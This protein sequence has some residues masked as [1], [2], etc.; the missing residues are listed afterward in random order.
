ME[1]RRTIWGGV[2][3]D[4]TLA[5]LQLALDTE[6]PEDWYPVGREIT[7]TWN[8]KSNPLIVAQYLDSTNNSSYGGAEGVI[9]VRKYAH[10]AVVFGNNYDYY[11]STI[12]NYLYTTYLNGC[13]ESLINLI[14]PIT[15]PYYDFMGVVYTPSK[16][17]IPSGI[18]MGSTYNSGDGIFWDYWKNRTGLSTANNNA[19]S[20]RVITDMNGANQRIWLRSVG[21]N[22]NSVCY[23]Y[24]DGRIN[25]TGDP[26]TSIP[27]IPACFI[28]KN[29]E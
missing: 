9:L 12:R 16:W 24:L 10:D 1:R 29:T 6:N 27:F 4:G 28:S 25:A 21:S 20:G 18:E 7:D 17:F 19:N 3:G 11:D 8:G 14:S 2:V 22:T 5:D 26:K 15:I 13:S 23:V